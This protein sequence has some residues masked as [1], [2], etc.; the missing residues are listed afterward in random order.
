MKIGNKLGVGFGLVLIMLVITGISGYWGIRHVSG[1]TIDMLSHE[2]KI[3]EHSARARANV[4]GLRRYEK[5]YFLNITSNEKKEEYFNKWNE[6][7]EHLLARLSDLENAAVIQKHKDLITTMRNEFSTYDNGFKDVLQM[8]QSGKIK[9]PEEANTAIGQYK[10]AIHKMEQSAKDLAEDGNKD[11]GLFGNNIKKVIGLTIY[12]IIAFALIGLIA[13]ITTGALI[14]KSITG[15]LNAAVG[16]AEK[17]AAGDMTVTVDTDGTDETGHLLSAMKKMSDN[18]KNILG[19][20]GQSSHHIAAASGELSATAEE[21][22]TSI[23]AQAEQTTQM[24]SSMEQM[25]SSIAEVARSTRNIVASASKAVTLA[26]NGVDV[27]GRVVEEVQKVAAIVNES[28]TAIG[29]LGDSSNQIGKIIAVIDDIADQTNLLALNAA[30]EAARAG[31]QGKGFAI[32]ADEV[33]RL[34]ERTTKATKEIALMNKTIQTDTAGAVAAMKTGTKEVHEGVSLA[35]QGG[36]SLRA[37]VDAVNNVNNMIN[38]IAAATQ[39]QSSAAEQILSGIENISA[40]TRGTS[41]G[42]EQTS[43][44]SQE[45]AKMTTEFEKLMRDFKV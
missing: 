43:S 36:E 38:Q 45:L 33:R 3:A 14:T 12:M 9:T 37:I 40:I 29:S 16:I 20:M 11:M 27:T 5:D 26:Q 6:Q 23:Q 28:S 44:A 4:L 7:R 21:M 10:A 39:Q 24:A 34:S 35:N 2:A 19:N 41:S 32:V 31:E 18:L 13:S 42:A 25:R 15:P 1:L 22:T 17:I 8:I 30:I